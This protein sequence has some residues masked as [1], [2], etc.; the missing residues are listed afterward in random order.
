[1]AWGIAEAFYEGAAGP[2]KKQLE[3]TRRDD[4]YDVPLTVTGRVKVDLAAFS[5]VLG[6]QGGITKQQVPRSRS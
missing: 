3:K 6:G 4:R 5:V 1:V 2:L